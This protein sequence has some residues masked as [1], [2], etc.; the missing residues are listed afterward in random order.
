MKCQGMTSLRLDVCNKV[1]GR[2]IGEGIYNA[3]LD[4]G[5]RWVASGK[6]IATTEGK[7]VGWKKTLSVCVLSSGMNGALTTSDYND[8]FFERV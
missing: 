7:V 2:E 4:G 1:A 8:W 5:K 3:S 6:T